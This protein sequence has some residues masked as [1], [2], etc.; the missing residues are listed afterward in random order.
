MPR[1]IEL[2]RKKT[3]KGFLL[4]LLGLLWFYFPGEYVLTANRDLSLFLPTPE[5]LLTFLDRPGGLLE[6]LGSFLSQFYRIR[7][8]GAM[9]LGLVLAT[10][11]MASQKLFTRISGRKASPAVG[12]ISA[13]L[14]LGMHNFYPHQLSHSLGLLLTLVLAAHVPSGSSKRRIYLVLAVPLIYLASGG[15]VWLFSVLAFMGILVGTKKADV[16][17]ILLCFLY[18]VL[19]IALGASFIFLYPWKELAVVQLPFGPGYGPSFWPILFV[20]WVFLMMLLLRFPTGGKKF[21]GKKLPRLWR[22]G[23]EIAFSLLASLLI[24][25]FSFNRKNAELFA[26]EKLA[27]QEDWASLLAFTEEHPSTNLFGSYY[28]NL[29]LAQEGL[30]LKDLFKYPQGFGRRGLCFEW[31]EKSE[32]LRRGSDFFWAIL[33]VNEAH[34]WAFESWIIDGPTR[35]NLRRLIQTELVRGNDKIAEKYIDYLGNALFQIKLAKRY[36][37]F[38]Y[39][40]E[41]V[42]EDPELGPRFHVQMPND[43]FSEGADLEKNLRSVLANQPFNPLALDYLMALYL[44]EKQVDKIPAMLPAYRKA[45]RG[46]LPILLEESLLVYQITHRENPIP[47]LQIS[48]ATLQRFEAYTQVL[49][50]YRNPEDAARMLYPNYKDTF[51]FHLNFNNL[52]N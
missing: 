15:F 38:L 29:A 11:Y 28:T 51:W 6:Y 14:V 27:I 7:L 45:H 24:L 42:L 30:L 18:P 4:F 10:M 39:Q 12:I 41:V 47:D 33:F 43:F 37:A 2:I 26:I 1:I 9:V 32:I 16:P 40:P 36:A 34:H 50:Q 23:L 13:L 8:A 3:F 35:R 22:T 25:H 5:Y 19:I 17:S 46:S 44:L 31:E 49:R 20:A 48:P 21:G 52:A